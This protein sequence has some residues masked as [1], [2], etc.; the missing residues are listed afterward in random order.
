MRI[1]SNILILILSLSFFVSPAMVSEHSEGHQLAEMSCCAGENHS[2]HDSSQTKD[3]HK[4]DQKKDCSDTSCPMSH[5]QSQT[6][7]VK[8]MNEPGF[9]ETE[10][11]IPAVQKIFNAHYSSLILKELIYSFWH[12]PKYIS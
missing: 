5:C 6:F 10:P 4:K 3:Q 11:I 7:S 12:P 2:C 1:F 8:L 9:K